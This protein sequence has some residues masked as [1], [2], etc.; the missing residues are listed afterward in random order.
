MADQKSAY[1]EATLLEKS[2]DFT[3]YNE[4]SLKKLLS[5]NNISD[6]ENVIQDFDSNIPLVLII[7]QIKQI[8]FLTCLLKRD[9]PKSSRIYRKIFRKFTVQNPKIKP[10]GCYQRLTG[11]F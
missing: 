8:K 10:A 2:G 9:F 7:R 3:K 5:V 4:I 1:S 11:L 6:F